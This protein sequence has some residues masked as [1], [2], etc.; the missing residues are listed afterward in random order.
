[1][2]S[3]AWF[4]STLSSFSIHSVKSGVSFFMLSGPPAL[5]LI[6]ALLDMYCTASIA[7]MRPARNTPLV[8][9]LYDA[10]VN[11]FELHMSMFWGF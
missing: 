11:F 8:P 2:P 6:V 5:E 10:E 3:S 7:V 1:M 9:S 4:A